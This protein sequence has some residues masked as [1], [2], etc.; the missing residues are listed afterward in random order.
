MFDIPEFD[1]DIFDEL[2]STSDYLIEKA[3]KMVV[4][5]GYAVL[6]RKQTAGRGRYNRQW[7]DKGGNI[8][9]SFLLKPKNMDDRIGQVSLT[10]SVAAYE[11]MTAFGVSPDKIRLKWPNDILLDERKCS[12]FLIEKVQTGYVVG[13]GI[14]V[15]SAPEGRACLNEFSDQPIDIEDF[16]THFFDSF[17]KHYIKLQHGDFETIKDLWLS[18]AQLHGR[19][20]TVKLRDEQFE[21]T[22]KELDHNGALIVERADTGQGQVITSAEIFD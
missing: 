2:H 15:K 8:V 3:E 13:I 18:K 20:L 21:A 7:E 4:N 12:G 9:L 22:A 19:H 10:V 5:S 1:L 14:N 16:I 6:A 11:T 17:K